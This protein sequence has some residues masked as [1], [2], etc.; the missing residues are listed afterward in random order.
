MR[1]QEE[2]IAW[3]SS[4]GDKKQSPLITLTLLL[5]LV[6]SETLYTQLNPSTLLHMQHKTQEQRDSALNLCAC[7]A[8]D[9]L[10][11]LA[12]VAGAAH[13]A[14]HARPGAER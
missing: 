9:E 8:L 4:G 12:H 1:K 5:L 13:T 10:G 7:F 11:E 14:S 3:Q 2:H 6:R